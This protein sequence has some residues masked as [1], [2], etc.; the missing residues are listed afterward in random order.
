MNSNVTLFLV[1]QQITSKM[2][3]ASDNKKED[4]KDKAPKKTV[5]TFKDTDEVPRKD[6]N[7][8]LL[9]IQAAVDTFVP[10]RLIG[11]AYTVNRTKYVGF[12]TDVWLG[13]MVNYKLQPTEKNIKQSYISIWYNQVDAMASGGRA[14]EIGWGPNYYTTFGELKE[15]IK[16]ALDSDPDQNEN[17]DN[18]EPF[19]G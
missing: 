18:S 9:M 12:M 13:G 16:D 4:N 11:E 8:A 14:V 3:S 5:A 2:A 19:D 7:R 1:V 15:A 10:K 17:N 6:D